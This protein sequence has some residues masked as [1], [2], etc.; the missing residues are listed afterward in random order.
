MSARLKHLWTA[1]ALAICAC[2][3][4]AAPAD[5]GVSDLQ[6]SL[7]GKVLGVDGAP[8]HIARAGSH[9]GPAVAALLEGPLSANAA[10]RIG[11]LNNPELQVALGSESTAISDVTSR[12]APAKL[13]VRQALTTLSAVTLKAWIQ[14]VASAQS[15]D[16]L[17]EAKATAQTRN[18][19]ARRMVRVGNLSPLAQA[20][21]QATLSDAALALAR[22]EQ[23]A[24]SAREKLIQL[25]GLWGEQT[26]F[27]LPPTLPALPEQAQDMPD[28]ESL[29]LAARADLAVARA[30]WDFKQRSSTPGSADD[31]WDAMADAARVRA[32][33]VKVRS[34]AREAY[35]HYRSTFDIAQHLQTEVLPLRKFINDELLLRYNGMLT[36]VFDVLADSQQQ[37]LSANAALLAQRDFWLAHTDL[38][39]VL[40]GAPREALGTNAASETPNSAGPGPAGH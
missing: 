26:R 14:A 17:R 9:G 8:V 2:V 15:A 20:Q 10:V 32:L 29:A 34:Q 24:F 21:H 22:A 5:G 36:S 4:V 27:V 39:A 25:L 11:L 7:V 13:R 16:F 18:E 33:A 38:L 1:M 12:E 6:N 23:E 37:T 28:V 40:A 3:A 35:F 30:Q 31:L 19:L